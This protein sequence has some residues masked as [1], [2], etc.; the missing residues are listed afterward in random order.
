MTPKTREEAAK[1]AYDQV[2]IRTPQHHSCS[3][4]TLI[5]LQE[6]FGVKDES[7]FKAAS[8]LRGGIGRKGNICGGFLGS[9][10]MLGLMCGSSIKESGAPKENYDPEFLDK[11]TQLVGELFDWFKAR[12]GTMICEELVKR[13]VQELN[14]DTDIKTLSKETMLD[15]IHDKCHL[16]CAQTA[17]RTAEV[18]WDELYNGK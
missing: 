18:L 13:Y 15:R 8:G 3:L 16:M 4:G 7:A 11:P 6:A 5:S 9:S 1:K 2:L 14:A 17:A 12:F 10:I